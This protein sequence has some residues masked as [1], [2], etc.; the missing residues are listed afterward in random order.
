MNINFL[1]DHIE[2]FIVYDYIYLGDHLVDER[3]IFK[4]LNLIINHLLYTLVY[5]LDLEIYG[6]KIG[7][8]IGFIM[9]IWVYNWPK[10]IELVFEFF[11]RFFIIVLMIFCLSVFRLLKKSYNFHQR[12][13]LVILPKFMINNFTC[14][15]RN[16]S[17][18]NK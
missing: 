7:F 9:Q 14:N 10:I 4:N 1:V 13:I 18:L 16:C 11:P 2:A 5:L 15:L 12:W 6:L 3:V 17:T 8:F